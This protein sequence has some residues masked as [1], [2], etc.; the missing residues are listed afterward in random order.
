[1]ATD[2]AN[3]T[4]LV[5]KGDKEIDYNISMRNNIRQIQ[6]FSSEYIFVNCLYTNKLRLTSSNDGMSVSDIYRWLEQSHLFSMYF[7]FW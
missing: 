3:E 4:Y 5:F 1:M 7:L 2:F 6:Y